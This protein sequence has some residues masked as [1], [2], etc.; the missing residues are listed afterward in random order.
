MKFPKVMTVQ[1]STTRFVLLPLALACL[2]GQAHAQAKAP[3]AGSIMQ[4]ID[5]DRKPAAPSMPAAALAQ[6]EPSTPSQ[7]E[8]TVVVKQFVV[9]GNTLIAETALQN[10]LRPYAHRAL[11]MAE[12][13]QAADAIVQHY[14]DQGYLTRTILPKQD[15]TEGTVRIQVIESSFSGTEIESKLE[16]KRI[17]AD[18]LQNTIA[19]QIKPGDP[20]SLKK[21]E[22]GLML[23]DDIPGVNVTGRLAAGTSDL[24]TGVVLN[25]SDE[26]LIYGEAAIDNFG[27][28]STGP[29]RLTMNGTMSG[30]LQMGDQFSLFTMKTQGIEFAR[31]G[32]SLPAGYDGWRIGTNASTMHY[33]IVEGPAG[34]GTSVVLGLDANYPIYR[35]RP[36]NLNYVANLDKKFFDNSNALG[37]TTTKYHSLVLSTGFNGSMTD[38]ILPGGLTSGNV[39]LSLG[40]VNL[41]GSPNQA[42]DLATVKAQGGFQ[43][44]KYTATHTQNITSD[45]VGFASF[46]GQ[47]ASK[48]L[49]SSEKFYLGG[50][51]GVRAYPNN[52]GGGSNGQLLTLEL[53][54]NLPS[55]LVLTA[56]YDRGHVTVNKFNDFAGAANPNQMSYAGA[57]L[58]LAWYGPKNINV[59]AIW[60]RRLGVNPYPTSAGTDQ[61]GTQTLNRFWFSASIP[62]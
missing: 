32:F 42:D 56:F 35:S 16:G 62:F 37:E 60:S 14:L 28:Y 26:P 59:K 46:A 53:R 3:D 22:R 48:N 7:G 52:E 55:D 6:P 29:V 34:K 30:A 31:L 13:Q 50:P 8:A 58:Q 43:K 21:L 51:L 12:L 54:Q 20:M 17:S 61:D 41:N 39:M 9:S 33:K 23:A 1:I 25:V 44:L 10:V 15:V 45:L 38:K 19:A 5:R 27:S 47:V 40:T 57:G 18:R 2:C 11:T 24:T 4:G 49:D 36:D